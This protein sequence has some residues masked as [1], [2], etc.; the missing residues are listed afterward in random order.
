MEH[1]YR[2]NAFGRL[3]A[4]VRADDG[5]RV[6]DLGADGKR[7]PAGLQIPAT[8]AA[9]ELAQYLGDLLHEH[10]SPKYPDVVP[11]APPARG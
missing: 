4:V 8:L 3:L 2:F 9:D 7:R 5:W 6:F 10:A 11:V 1:E